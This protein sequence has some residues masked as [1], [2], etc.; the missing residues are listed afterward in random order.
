MKGLIH[1][2]E[3]FSTSDGPGIR[4]VVFLQGCLLRCIYC[5]NPDTWALKS[6]SAREYSVEDL[7][8]VVLRNK[9]FFSPSG[10]GLTFSGGEPMLQHHF[11]TAVFKQCRQNLIHTAFESSLFCRSHNI[12][13]VL[14]YTDLVLADIK[15]TNSTH[16]TGANPGSRINI[17]N[18]R[19]INQHNIPIWLRYVVLPGWTDR[20]SDF[21][22]LSSLARLLS[23]VIKIELLPYHGLGRHKWAYMG[24]D[25]PLA[26]VSPP[27]PAELKKIADKI[28]MMSCKEVQVR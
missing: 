16:L 5:Q 15:S 14:P 26:D 20:P 11:V 21:E 17:E 18:L 24:L 4:T 10:G 28:S 25:Y 22:H 2:I 19:M 1:S 6:E 23:N 13:E 9:P 3:T 12:E 7:S 27:D 8:K